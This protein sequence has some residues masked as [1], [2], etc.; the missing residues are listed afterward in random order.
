MVEF[1]LF[2]IPA[3][4]YLLVQSRR[5]HGWRSPLSRLGAAWGRPSDYAMAAL[6]LVPLI[7]AGWLAIVLIPSGALDAPG[8]SVARLTSVGAA[9]S[10]VLR[11]IGEEILF[12]GLLGGIFVRRLGFAGGNLLQA[13]VFAVPHLALLAIDVRTWPIIPVQFA[14]GWLLGWLRT[15]S[16]SFVP[17]AIVHA[18]SNLAAG[19]IVAMTGS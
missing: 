6:L 9:V 10:V 16:G 2:C 3:G 12:R 7:L 15:R 8:V 14:A 18:A 1:V 17:G 19:I 13:A 11:A 5:R 4:V